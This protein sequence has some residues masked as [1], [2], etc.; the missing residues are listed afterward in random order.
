MEKRGREKGRKGGR[1]K[2]EGGGDRRG[3]AAEE[4]EVSVR[5]R[6]H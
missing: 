3:E 2:E 5:V 4:G 1:E 6:K